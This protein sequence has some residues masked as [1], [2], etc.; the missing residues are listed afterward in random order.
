ML[1]FLAS[2]ASALPAPFPPLLPLPLLSCSHPILLSSATASCGLVLCGWC[3][4]VR[5]CVSWAARVPGWVGWGEAPAS[6]PPQ[7]C[8]LPGGANAHLSLLLFQS[9]KG[10]DI[11]RKPPESKADTI[12]SG[13]AIPIKQ[14]GISLPPP[15]SCPAA[16]LALGR[17]ASGGGGRA[18]AGKRGGR[19]GRGVSVLGPAVSPCHVC[20][21]RLC[22]CVLCSVPL[23]CP[24]KNP[25]RAPLWAGH[26]WPSILLCFAFMSVGRG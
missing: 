12:G 14:V 10:P 13:R 25:R 20:V 11:E 15:E 23:L 7:P 18:E 4:C 3:A 16:G 5:E 8:L 6:R 9:R 24:W 1:F 22:P 19:A 17:W 2:A 21:D 26:C